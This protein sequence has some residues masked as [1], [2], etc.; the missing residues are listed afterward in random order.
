M[1]CSN[2]SVCTC[3]RRKDGRSEKVVESYLCICACVYVR[4]KT[5]K[6]IAAKHV[7][8]RWL[9]GCFRMYEV[10]SKSTESLNDS[11]HTDFDMA[12]N[13]F[14]LAVYFLIFRL[15]SCLK[16]RCSLG[17][18]EN[19]CKNCQAKNE[20]WKERDCQNREIYRYLRY[21]TAPNR[22]FIFARDQF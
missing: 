8:T 15:S 19:E 21:V 3:V 20:R 16:L 9:N 13:V 5:K 18:P 2:I 1:C 4:M 7:S 14:P 11:K 17:K 12:M 6:Y 22:T 10:T